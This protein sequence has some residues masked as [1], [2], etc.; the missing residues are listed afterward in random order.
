MTGPWVLPT[1]SS[2]FLLSLF[3]HASLLAFPPTLGRQSW[4]SKLVDRLEDLSCGLVQETNGH[5]F[6]PWVGRIPWRTAWQPPQ[7]SYL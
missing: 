3:Q 1:L 7:Y 4:K 2:Y 6:D 5:G